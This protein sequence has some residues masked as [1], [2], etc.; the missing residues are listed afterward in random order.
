M[1]NYEN[2]FLLPRNVTLKIY[3]AE[4]G[5]RKIFLRVYYGVSHV[6]Y[7][8]IMFWGAFKKFFLIQRLL[9]DEKHFVWKLTGFFLIFLIE[10]ASKGLK[11]Y[12]LYRLSS[13]AN[14]DFSVKRFN[15]QATQPGHRFKNSY[16][17]W[18]SFS[19]I[20]IRI[21]SIL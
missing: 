13:V 9:Y 8:L 17:L 3:G 15:E 11:F 5:K 6:L 2:W 20:L 12:F 4:E 7:V 10:G 21:D 18:L 19:H 16:F 14:L 1:A